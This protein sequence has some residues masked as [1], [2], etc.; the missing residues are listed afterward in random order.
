M[1][2]QEAR[3]A[4]ALVLPEDSSVLSGL[5]DINFQVIDFATAA[6]FALD[7]MTGIPLDKGG[8]AP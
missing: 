1:E 5:D 8:D 2:R 4:W 7:P 6:A 3:V